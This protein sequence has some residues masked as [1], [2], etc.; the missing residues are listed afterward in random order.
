LFFNKL[1]IEGTTIEDFKIYILALLNE[2]KAPIL[3][4][5]LK[6]NYKL[7]QDIN[8]L[9]AIYRT[10]YPNKIEVYNDVISTLTYLKSK[11]YKLFILT[12]NP[13]KTQEIKMNLIPEV[14]AIFHAV[15]F[16]AD[17][18]SE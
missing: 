10:C 7:S 13:K 11:Q 2:G 16:T 5:E 8:E 12:D 3:I 14:M 9:I 18:N 17:L 4:N 1:K 15:F 6:C